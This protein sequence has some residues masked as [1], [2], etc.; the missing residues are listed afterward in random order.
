[1]AT[2]TTRLL[3]RKPDPDPSTGDFINVV[4]DI[5]NSMDKI[6]AAIGVTVCTSGTRP[7]GADRWDGREIYETDTRRNYM[8]NSSLATWLPLLVGRGT[9]GPYL[10]GQSTDT[11][12]EGINSRGS[13][14]SANMWRSRVTSDA[15]PRFTIQ[16]DGFMS[17]GPGSGAVD[18]TLG[19]NAAATLKVD[20]HL[21]VDGNLTVNG[22]TGF[23]RFYQNTLGTAVST[24]NVP[25]IPATFDQILAVC[26][27]A[28]TAATQYVSVVL[29]INGDATTGNYDSEQVYGAGNGSAGMGESLGVTGAGLFLG[30]MPGST[31]VAG[32]SAAMF[33]DI[34]AY[35]GTTFWKLPHSRKTLSSQTSGGQAGQLWN[36]VWAHRWKATSAI[37]SIEWRAG[38]GNFAVGSRFYV[39]LMGSN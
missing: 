17:W 16:A 27:V 11:T 4:T 3:L 13:A 2:T 32:S 12:G 22:V 15:N 36:K 7:T 38:T 19:R 33:C 34:P 23:K 6:D 9:D 24:V 29:R 14:T 37:T 8:W 35:A 18:T 28:G 26:H 31:C 39:Y 10:L 1:M 20:D 5:N 21:I 25:S 30:D